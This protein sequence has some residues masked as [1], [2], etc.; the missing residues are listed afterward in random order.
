MS[1]KSS[2]AAGLGSLLFLL[3]LMPAGLSAQTPDDA[4]QQGSFKGPGGC[5]SR[6]DCKAYC[7]VDGHQQECLDF[8]VAN[9]FMNKDEAERAKKFLNQTGPGGCRGEACRTYCDDP[10]HGEECIDFAVKNGLIPKDEAERMKKFMQIEKGGG[11]PGGCRGEACRTYCDDS[12]HRDECFAFAK[13]KGLLRPEEEQHYEAG[14]KINQKIKESGGPGGC[15][16]E[17]SCHSYC[18][19][20]GHIE[21]CV[22]FGAAQTGRSEAEVTEML[23]EFKEFKNRKPGPGPGFDDMRSRR[24][25][26]RDSSEFRGRPEFGDDQRNRMDFENGRGEQDRGRMSGP[27]GCTSEESCRDFCSTH[28]EECSKFRPQGVPDDR[29]QEGRPD[30][31]ERS[32]GERP[33][34]RNMTPEQQKMFEEYQ[35]NP[36]EFQEMR[37]PEGMMPPPPPPTSELPPPPPPTS[38]SSQVLDT[39]FL[40]NALS[41]FLQ[42]FQG[43]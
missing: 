27:G 14:K 19:D 37:L 36:S 21:E 29:M 35:K 42:L 12:A 33:D 9:G 26:S 30:F 41:A 17:E 10:A 38:P 5:T 7:D 31:Q 1:Y 8:A 18:S 28:Q 2:L 43:R 34:P 40:A 16:S 39:S 23:R 24:D 32:A 20:P 4:D 15:A 6:E 13:E 22:K 25:E 11:G 3:V